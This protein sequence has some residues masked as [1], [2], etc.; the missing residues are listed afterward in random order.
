MQI[1]LVV[2][3]V[4]V[5]VVECYPQITQ[6]YSMTYKMYKRKVLLSSFLLNDH[7][8]IFHLITQ[9]LEPPCTAE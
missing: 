6:L 4:V 3:V 5:V 1:K 2:V 8:L 9:K 7:T